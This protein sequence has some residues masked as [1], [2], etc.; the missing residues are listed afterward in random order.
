MAKTRTAFFCQSCGAQSPRWIG[1]CPSCG[2]WNTYVEEVVERETAG[3]KWSRQTGADNA[4]PVLIEEIDMTSHP[5]LLTGMQEFDRVLGGGIV[6]GSLILIGGEPGIGKSTLSLQ[7]AM[8]MRGSKILY[9]SGEESE[10]QL[11]MRAVRL[12]EEHGNC[13]ILTETSTSNILHYAQEMNPDLIVVDSIQTLQSQNI[14]SSAGSIS[15]I[16]ETAAEL[17]RFAKSTATPVI[18]IGHI[19]KEGL[20]AGPKVLEHMVDVV[21]LFEGE[22]HYGFRLLRASKN[23]FGSAAELAIFEMSDTGMR[24]ILNPSEVLISPHEEALSGISVATTLEGLR[25]MLIEVQAL[26]SASAY[27]TPQRS[28]TGFDVRRLHMLLA[29]LE[30]R[31][32]LRSGNRDVFLNIT[33]GIRVDDPATD[34]AV[35]SAVL[36]SAEDIP[37]PQKTCF[38]GEVGLSGEVRVIN[39]IEQRLAEAERMGYERIFIPRH[40]ARSIRQQGRGIELIPVG[41]VH[42]AFSRL[43]G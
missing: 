19:T 27:G 34:L 30:K 10:Q 35:V 21:L 4:R 16:R 18:M 3:N 23:R 32:G 26:V 37:I 6:R 41:S 17:Q 40:A 1:R 2:E 39:R 24:E 36:S 31:A 28:A 43:F 22:R 8:R 29:V 25:P 5:R 14:E 12:G 7:M 11:K 33:G 9:V 38:A 15:Q 13:Y 20:I 42:E